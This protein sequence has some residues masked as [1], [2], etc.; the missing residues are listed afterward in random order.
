M[1]RVEFE[2]MTAVLERAKTVHALDCTANVMG[3]DRKQF[4]PKVFSYAWHAYN[5]FLLSFHLC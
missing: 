4:T 2:P 1:S 3:W 5:L